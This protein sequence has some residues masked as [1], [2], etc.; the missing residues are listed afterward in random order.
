[1]SSSEQRK[2]IFTEQDSRDAERL[3]K[4]L[5][6]NAAKWKKAAE[7]LEASAKI[8]DPACPLLEKGGS[9]QRMRR[10]AAF[11]G[12]PQSTAAEGSGSGLGKGD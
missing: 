3:G 12:L 2:V 9:P 11:D 6:A 1:M 10:S 5:E 8:A 7:R 4:V